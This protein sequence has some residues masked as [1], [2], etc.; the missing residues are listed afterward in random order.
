MDSI[1]AKDKL[2][3]KKKNRWQGDMEVYI[4]GDVFHRIITQKPK[5]TPKNKTRDNFVDLRTSSSHE[6]LSRHQYTKAS[7]Y[8]ERLQQMWEDS[9]KYFFIEQ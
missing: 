6:T 1:N 9:L 3:K 2:K 5:K 4:S 7:I 8:I